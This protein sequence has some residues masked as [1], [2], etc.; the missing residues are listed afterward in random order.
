MG[1]KDPLPRPLAAEAIVHVRKYPYWYTSVAIHVTAV[2][3]LGYFTLDL[4]GRDGLYVQTDAQQQKIVSSLQD[5]SQ[6][7]MQK[8]IENMAKIKE[9]LEQSLGEQ[10]ETAQQNQ[11]LSEEALKNKTPQELLAEAKK[12]SAAIEKI[13]DSAKAKELAELLKIS[14]QEA[15]E[16]IPKVEA[17][18]AAEE[19]Q[20]AK[21]DKVA[22]ELAPLVEK[23]QQQAED[24]LIE[25]EQQL[26]KAEN[27]VKLNA[28]H[29]GASKGKGNGLS[30]GGKG[31]KHGGAAGGATDE[32]LQA[33]NTKLNIANFLHG[34]MPLPAEDA[35]GN[36]TNFN[37]GSGHIPAVDKTRLHK[38]DGLV[39]GA[40]GEFSNRFY[41]N[42]WHIIGPFDGSSNWGFSTRKYPP[43]EAVNLKGVYAGK[44]NRLL[45]WQYFIAEEYPLVPPEFEESA[46]YY[47]YTELNLDQAS[48]L[49]VWVGADDNA[50]I[51]LNDHLVYEGGNIDKGWYF[52]EVYFGN[53]DHR[54]NWNF[55]EAKQLMHFKKG[56]N[57]IMFRLFNASRNGF[58]AMVL[59]K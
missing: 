6:L 33:E 2:A 28:D 13:K 15:L 59:S 38:G 44:N 11:T 51:W 58:F 40:G 18:V 16:K 29:E 7:K 54:D 23:L 21:E 36:S 57:K 42:R 24:A 19:D 39:L 20:D 34:D 35:A 8:S 14:E 22:T 4:F 43:E 37:Q 5:T 55:T 26:A 41:L 48:D 49:W 12:L 1:T 53:K 50:R 3:L 10:G 9:L 17:S 46:V 25:R 47:G 30:D 45:S 31:D 27:G 56:R 32:V 52:D